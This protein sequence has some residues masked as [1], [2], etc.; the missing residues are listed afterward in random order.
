MCDPMKP[1]PPVTSAFTIP[2]PRTRLSLLNPRRQVDERLDHAPP[3]REGLHLRVPP[4]P[5]RINLADRHLCPLIS[6]ADDF[7][8]KVL[9]ELILIE[10]LLLPVDSLV[11]EERGLE[12][13]EPVRA[14]GHP[15][16]GE[17]REDERMDVPGRKRAVEGHVSV[18]PSLQE[19]RPLHE[20]E[21][22]RENWP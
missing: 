12:G 16:A 11:E 22:A 7:E 18:C 15:T 6:Q 20:V 9:F 10:P 19:P 4:A 21:A 3:S 5:N 1:A 2:P 14:L 13:P 8:V 17:G